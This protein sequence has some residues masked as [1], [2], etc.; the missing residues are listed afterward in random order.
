MRLVLI[1]KDMP[2]TQIRELFKFL[3]PRASKRKGPS[4]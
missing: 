3:V 2:E 4:A 1:G